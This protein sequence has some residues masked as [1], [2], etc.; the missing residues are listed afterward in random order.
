MIRGKEE[1]CPHHSDVDRVEYVDP[2]MWTQ[3]RG[4]EGNDST[5]TWTILMCTV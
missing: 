2:G 3:S 4:P 5:S 1:A